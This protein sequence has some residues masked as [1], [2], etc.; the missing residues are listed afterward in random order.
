MTL[1]VSTNRG[2]D[3]K[4]IILS[5]EYYSALQWYN[6]ANGNRWVIIESDAKKNKQYTEKTDTKRSH[7]FVHYKVVKLVKWMKPATK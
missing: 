6:V 5:L 2:V 1:C 3:Y 7:L 4:C